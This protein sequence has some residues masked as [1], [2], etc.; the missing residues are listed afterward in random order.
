ML[1]VITDSTVSLPADMVEEYGIEELSLF[2]HKDGVDHVESEMDLDEFYQD[3][4]GM[5]DNIPTSSQPALGLIEARFEEAAKAGD[6]V[7]AIILS[8]KLSGTVETFANVAKRVTEKYPDFK[9]SVIDSLT[10]CLEEGWPVIAGAVAR[11]AG[12][13]LDECRKKVLE[14]MHSTRFIFAPESLR[15]LEAGGRIGKASALIGNILNISPVLT[16]KDGFATTYGKV[17]TQKKAMAKMVN[18]FKD[19]IKACGLKNIVVHYIG[20]KDLA[21]K[22]AREDVEPLVGEK[23][24]VLP[25]SPVIGVHV[26]PAVGLAYECCKPLPGKFS[27]G[28]TLE[29]Y[30]SCPAS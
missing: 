1:R 16:V 29:L 17:R 5:V 22:W 19:D 11:N 2:V 6:E 3:I 23:V 14:S 10:T 28:T 7:L 25:A 13:G 21:E 26:G 24:R 4:Y 27:E 12:Y 30:T 20:S 18:V 15:F 9:C 8:G